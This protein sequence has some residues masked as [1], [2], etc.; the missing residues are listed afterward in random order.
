MDLLDFSENSLYFDEPLDQ[1][2]KE[3]I[4][5]AS[6]EYG[7]NDV[8]PLLLEALD[9]APE[10]LTVLVALYRFYY[11]QH[12]LDDALEVAHQALLVSGERLNFPTDWQVIS[13]EHLGAG[14][15]ISM[16]ML[17]FYLLALKAAGFLNLRL[18]RWEQAIAMLAKVSGLDEA[19]RLGCA[20]LLELANRAHQA[21]SPQQAAL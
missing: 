17:R 18:K 5:Q 21:E 2:A 15:Q 19:D 9:I 8:E 10:H 13:D 7:E 16:A 14:A 20:P 11:Y 1:R 12:R 3:L 4:D 6:D